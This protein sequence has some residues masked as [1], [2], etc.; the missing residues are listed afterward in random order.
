MLLGAT[1]GSMYFDLFISLTLSVAGVVAGLGTWRAAVRSNRE[2]KEQSER[3]RTLLIPREQPEQMPSSPNGSTA[4]EP[5]SATTIA[6]QQRIDDDRFAELLVAYY[7]YGLSQ[8]RRSFFS[9]QVFSGFGA[10]ILLFG[11][12]LAIWR[13]ETSGDMYAGI[14]TSTSGVVATIIGQLFHRRA[15]LALT[16]MATQTDALRDDM[17]SERSTE[18]AL[19]LLAEVEDPEIKARLQAGLIMKLSGAEMPT[20]SLGTSP[21]SA[22]FS[23]N[24]SA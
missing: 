12:A 18:Q 17:R 9:S 24:H 13:A 6:A 1:G 2:Q 14:V 3:L 19:M 4:I 8:A 23:E 15:D 21:S 7:D 10:G 16:H 11:I 22:M 5:S 20:F